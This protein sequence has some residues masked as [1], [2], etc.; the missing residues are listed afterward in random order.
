MRSKWSFFTLTFPINKLKLIVPPICAS[1]C[2]LH[3]LSF[4]E[5][6]LIIMDTFDPFV[7]RVI[8]FLSRNDLASFMR[9]KFAFKI[10]VAG[11]VFFSKL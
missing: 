3:I 8:F 5:E 4:S 1:I 10:C 7:L 9:S 6:Y 11:G 2:M